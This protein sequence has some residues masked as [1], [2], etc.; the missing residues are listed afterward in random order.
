MKDLKGAAAAYQKQLRER[1]KTN[2]DCIDCGKNAPEAEKVRCRS[3]LERRLGYLAARGRFTQARAAAIRR[4]GR[5]GFDFTREEFEHR[6]KEPCEYCGLANDCRFG[7]GLDRIDNDLGYTKLNTVP[8]CY[9]CNM[10]R[11]DRF[12]PH[13]MRMFIGPA[14]RAAKI[15]RMLPGEAAKLPSWAPKTA[16]FE[17]ARRVFQGSLRRR[18]A[19]REFPFVD[20]AA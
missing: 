13:Q 2:G 1:R 19:N 11:G 14:I 15:S 16:S 5:D 9:D 4:F 18:I 7:S 17:E 12:S 3:C 8:C 20:G 6:I 10:A